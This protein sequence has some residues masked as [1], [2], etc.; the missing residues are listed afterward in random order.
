MTDETYQFVIPQVSM[1]MPDD[2][3]F[4]AV[5]QY[6]YEVWS[7]TCQW[8]EGVLTA[9]TS[10]TDE[11]IDADDLLHVFTT[12]PTIFIHALFTD[13]MLGGSNHVH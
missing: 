12:Y 9:Y 13:K 11:Y 6:N 5:W 7:A 10:M 1:S 4:I 3:Q 8:R 2:G